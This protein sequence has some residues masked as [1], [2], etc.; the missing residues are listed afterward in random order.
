MA[1]FLIAIFLLNAYSTCALAQTSKLTISKEEQ[2]ARD[3]DRHLILRTELTAEHQ[4]LAHAQTAFAA[5]ATSDRAAEVHRRLENI[6]ALQRELATVDQREPPK[7]VHVVAKARQ[8]VATTHARASI[9]AAAF[10]NPYNRA[11]DSEAPS[12]FPTTP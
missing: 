10:W 5:A 1:R 7:P 8:S 12:N 9:G 2:Q 6:K 3:R 11:P 4:A